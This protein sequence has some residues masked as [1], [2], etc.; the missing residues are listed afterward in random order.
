MKIMCSLKIEEQFMEIDIHFGVEKVYKIVKFLHQII[1][2]GSDEWLL[3][4]QD[5]NALGMRIYFH[6]ENIGN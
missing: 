1:I 2:D 3:N 5:I 4:E 6:R